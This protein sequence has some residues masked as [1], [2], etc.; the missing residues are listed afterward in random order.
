M[1]ND[2]EK[3]IEDNQQPYNNSTFPSIIVHDFR[4]DFVK[5]F[6]RRTTILG[7]SIK[8]RSIRVHGTHL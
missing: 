3:S 7:I 6:W 5:S 1:K 8:N 4:G 2:C